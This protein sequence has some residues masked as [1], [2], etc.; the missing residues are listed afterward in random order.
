[1]AKKDR[2]EDLVQDLIHEEDWKRMNAT[3]E[4]LKR[5]PEAVRHLIAKGLSDGNA[6]L[7]TEAVKMLGRIKDRT[8]GLPTVQL[9]KDPYHAVRVAPTVEI[10]LV[11]T[12]P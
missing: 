3:A 9:I 2:T 7:R 1:M 10:G 5:G 6:R 12:T 11:A 4:L 8:A